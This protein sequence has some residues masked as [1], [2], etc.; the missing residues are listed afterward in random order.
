[1]LCSWQRSSWI[2]FGGAVPRFSLPRELC[3]HVL[4]SWDVAGEGRED[5]LIILSAHLLTFTWKNFLNFLNKCFKVEKNASNEFTKQEFWLWNFQPNCQECA[6]MKACGQ[7]AYLHLEQIVRASGA[8]C[9]LS[10]PHYELFWNF[11]TKS[12]FCLS[13]ICEIN[14]C[15]KQY[16]IL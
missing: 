12:H 10:F 7:P 15:M 11:Y 13:F 16:M 3:V 2:G 14:L 4:G 6:F 1:M 9:S 5:K 8:C